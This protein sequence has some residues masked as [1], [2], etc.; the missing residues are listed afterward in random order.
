MERRNLNPAR[1]K[2]SG[3]MLLPVSEKE[4]QGGRAHGHF[5]MHSLKCEG[6]SGKKGCRLVYRLL[7]FQGFSRFKCCFS[8]PFCFLCLQPQ[9]ISPRR[10]SPPSCKAASPNFS[11]CVPLLGLSFC[12]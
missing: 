5:N 12:L 3:T 11:L 2:I 8:N 9:S 4:G 10:K 6:M 1:F 7:R